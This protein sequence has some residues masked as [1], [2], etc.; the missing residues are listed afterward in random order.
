MLVV[1][2][3]VSGVS[4]RVAGVAAQAVPGQ[5]AWATVV[6]L[7]RSYMLVYGGCIVLAALA[8]SR[9][10]FGRREHEARLAHLAAV[11][12]GADPRA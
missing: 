9:F 2:L 8:Y 1:C 5:G 4:V 11:P 3:C 10:P 12:I 6:L 7:G